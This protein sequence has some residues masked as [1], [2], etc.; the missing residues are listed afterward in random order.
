MMP[1]YVFALTDQPPAGRPG[2]GLA[3]ALTVRPVPGGFAIVERRADVP[4]VEFSSLVTHEQVMARLSDA[5]PAILPVRFGTLMELDE[6]VDALQEREEEMA[7]A[8]DRVRSRVQFTWRRPVARQTHAGVGA[9]KAE[10]TGTDYLR[11]AARAALPNSA[12]KSVRSALR[13]IVAEERY[14]PATPSLPDSLYHLVDRSREARYRLLAERLRTTT[15]A[16]R[17]TG[18]FAPFAFTPELL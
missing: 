5:A 10:A 1:W 9:R 4:P 3:G 11:R 13:T 16:L 8:F 17:L 15:P 14:Q 18:P 7:E 2:R 12:F 6:M